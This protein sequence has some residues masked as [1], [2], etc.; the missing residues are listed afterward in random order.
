MDLFH[1]RRREMVNLELLSILCT[2][3]PQ[4]RDAHLILQQTRAGLPLPDPSL[5]QSAVCSL[6]IILIKTT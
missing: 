3:E 1:L 6:S 2:P 4:R 5:R